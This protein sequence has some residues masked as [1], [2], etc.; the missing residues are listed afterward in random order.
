MGDRSSRGKP[1]AASSSLPTDVAAMAAKRVGLASLTY[2]LSYLVFEILYS[3]LRPPYEELYG[4]AFHS[5]AVIAITSGIGLFWYSRRS[6]N[7]GLVLK[8]GLVF[9][10]FSSL[11]IA[12]GETKIPFTPDDII[13]G[14]SA[15]AV[16]IAAYS[17]LAPAPF[18][19]QL[20][21][22]VAAALMAP[23]GM[24]ISV[25]VF[26]NPN[27]LPVQWITYA[28]GPLLTSGITAFASRWVYRLGMELK[29][30]RELGS[31]ALTE[32]L[33]H[34][35]MGQVWRAKHRFL[36]REAA[37][38][39]IAPN[40][41]LDR[42]QQEARFTREARAIS[43]LENPH[44]V[45]IYD[46]GLSP[47]G[48]LYFAME[49]IRG[50][51]LDQF[52]RR[53]GPM[54]PS[55]VVHILLGV[56][57]SLEEAHAAG[58]THRDIKPSNILLGRLGLEHDFVKVVDFGLVKSAVPD[59]GL[60]TRDHQAI[61]TPAFISPEMAKGETENVDGRADLYSLACVADWLLTGR[62]LFDV[63]NP[64]ALLMKHASEDPAPMAERSELPVP[65][66]LETLLRRCLA[67]DP[68][69]RPQSCAEF[70]DELR[71][72][73]LETWSA[74]EAR[75]WWRTHLPQLAG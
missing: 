24:A 73:G 59:E 11:L 63:K 74:T 16:W 27:P 62:T 15:I 56:L 44:T 65:A 52:V 53:F 18:R 36:A 13:R 23:L 1:T 54:P 50:L 5:L 12:L 9:V 64:L 66:A 69:T 2:A 72:L 34:G 32:P 48:Q 57:D 33:G 60:L 35:A 61:G 39:L 25:F 30:A 31:Y 20:A 14:H 7:P 41:A 26:G 3:V 49:L 46:F 29:A 4:T 38:K 42:S 45:A 40:P 37:V 67:K 10:V 51:N 47:E 22:A 75:A 17:L 68:A 43:Q 19:Q 6:S 28:A 71:K 70:R 8:L 55:R 21:A 58:L